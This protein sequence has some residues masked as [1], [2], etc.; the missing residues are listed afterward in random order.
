MKYLQ[1]A[2]ARGIDVVHSPGLKSKT[3]CFSA[4]ATSF[5]YLRLLSGV[6]NVGLVCMMSGQEVDSR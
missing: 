4:V 2:V 5:T 1:Q 3:L 6:I